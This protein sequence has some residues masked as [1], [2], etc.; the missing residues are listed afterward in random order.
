MNIAPATALVPRRAELAVS[1]ALEDTRVV[2][3]EGPRQ[4]GKTTLI[5]KFVN[6]RR[7][8]LSLDDPVILANAKNDP[9]GF[10][11]NLDGAV[12]DEI[13]RAPELMLVIKQS[14][15]SNTAPGRFLL[16]GSANVM[17]L[18]TIGDSLAGRIEIVELFPF[19]QSELF[20]RNG[21]AID[22][23]FGK[24]P[25]KFGN[26]VLG[27]QL[28]EIVARG[29]YPEAVA[30]KDERRRVKWFNDYLDLI[31]DRDVR[32]ISTIDQLE[33]LPMLVRLLAEQSGQLSNHTNIASALQISRA[34]VA[35]Y[36]ETLERMFLIDTLPPWFSNRISRLIKTPKHHF[37]DSGLLSALRQF[38]P[39][40][41]QA[42]PNR[43]GPLLESFV[44]AEL[45]KLIGWSEARVTLSHFRTKEG[46]EVDFVLEDQQG[47][48]VGIEVKAS[49]TLRRGDF[50]GLRKLEAAAGDKFVRGLVLHDHDGLRP[51]SAKISGVPISVLW[52]T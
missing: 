50:S 26:P 38:S 29:G 43:F 18:P 25:L 52:S 30:R 24:E 8:Y 21:D 31:L 11:R 44:G 19:A 22:R 1:T 6:D 47:R 15:D 41:P 49:A 3:V 34:T 37:L 27:Q 2:L 23:F 42:N 20:G 12:I 4:A 5:R 36:I 17:A 45:R 35:R 46:D 39:V 32:D 51:V 10:I 28:A 7:P 48:V 16:T 40:P 33:K 9:V 13:Q 14:V